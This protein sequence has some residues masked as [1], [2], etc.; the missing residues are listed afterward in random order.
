MFFNESKKKQKFS[1][2]CGI[3]WKETPK[4]YKWEYNMRSGKYCQANQSS[5]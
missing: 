5:V 1:S 4:K 3:S 2:K